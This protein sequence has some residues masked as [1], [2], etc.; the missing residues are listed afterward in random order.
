MFLITLPLSLIIIIFGHKESQF[1]NEVSHLRLT[2]SLPFMKPNNGKIVLMNLKDTIH[3]YYYKNN[4]LYYL[5]YSEL[6]Q[7]GDSL[8]KEETKYS[9]FIFRKNS[10][11]GFFFKYQEDT[12]KPMRYLVD[13]FLSKRGQPEIDL[14]LDS[15]SFIERVVENDG[16]VMEKYYD[17]NNIKNIFYQD[18]IYFYFDKNLSDIDVSISKSI[19]K[20][21]KQ[22]LTKLRLLFNEKFS[23]EHQM[24]LPKREMCFELKKIEVDNQQEIINF[25]DRLNQSIDLEYQKRL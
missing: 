15:C 9:Y 19:D 22:K 13:S 18:S 3:I 14:R 1:A 10:N 24:I 25:I 11:S 21:K 20:M 2:F 12:T 6:N 4:V 17:K 23:N 8:L 16:I 7:D 5:P